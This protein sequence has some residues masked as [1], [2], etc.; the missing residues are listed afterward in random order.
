M[1]HIV[2]LNRKF[3]VSKCIR[4]S[5][6]LK[7]LRI[8]K[9]YLKINWRSTFNKEKLIWLNYGWASIPFGNK[10]HSSHICHNF[11]HMINVFIMLYIK[12]K[13]QF[14]SKCLSCLIKKVFF[15]II[16]KRTKKLDEISSAERILR[17][18]YW[19]SEL[20]CNNKRPLASL[21]TPIT[22]KEYAEW[23]ELNVT[24]YENPK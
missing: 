3:N 10:E 16:F 5:K 2:H 14:L 15:Q 23:V 22:S 20:I 9:I 7:K 17:H 24:K 4:E 11:D 13:W 21:R 12:I 18:F 6:T 19:K 8:L 1:S